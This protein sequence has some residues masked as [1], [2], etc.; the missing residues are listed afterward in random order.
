M[1]ISTC[2]YSSYVKEACR[3]YIENYK[4]LLLLLEIN[5]TT[6]KRK[7]F[8]VKNTKRVR[9]FLCWGLWLKKMENLEIIVVKCTIFLFCQR[10]SNVQQIY[11]E[12]SCPPSAFL[13]KWFLT[14]WRKTL[15]LEGIKWLVLNMYMF[16]YEITEINPKMSKQEQ[17]LFLYALWFYT[18]INVRSTFCL[19]LRCK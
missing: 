2:I 19:L 11:N 13:I 14:V 18:C 6:S 7:T 4:C 17:F 12:W 9:I 10:R 5:V 15:A 16:S 8:L 3:Y 1:E